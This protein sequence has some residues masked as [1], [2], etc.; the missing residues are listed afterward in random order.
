M[1]KSSYKKEVEFGIIFDKC[2]Y[3][4]MYEFFIAGIMKKSTIFFYNIDDAKKSNSN[5]LA[6]NGAAKK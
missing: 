4:S 5:I 6:N 1:D 3:W 2:V